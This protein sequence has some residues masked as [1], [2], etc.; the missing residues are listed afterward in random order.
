MFH[1]L[2]ATEDVW[3]SEGGLVVVEFVDA[4]GEGAAAVGDKAF[5]VGS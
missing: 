5:G 3:T 1:G 2:K 4:I